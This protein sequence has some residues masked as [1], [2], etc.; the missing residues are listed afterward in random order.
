MLCGIQLSW[1]VCFFILPHFVSPAA[2]KYDITVETVVGMKDHDLALRM[3]GH[4]L[5]LRMEDGIMPPPPPAKDV[6]VQ[7]PGMAKGNQVPDGVNITNQ[8]TLQ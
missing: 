2:W 8:L 6:H 4:E 5:A 7:I 1:Q 3:E